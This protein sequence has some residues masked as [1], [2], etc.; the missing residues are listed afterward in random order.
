MEG[1]WIELNCKWKIHDTR[2]FGLT[3]R[4]V[5]VEAVHKPLYIRCI[6]SRSRGQFRFIPKPSYKRTPLFVIIIS[7]VPPPRVTWWK[8][9]LLLDD[10][11]EILPDGSVKNVLH[12]PRI[13]RQHLHTVSRWEFN[14]F[15]RVC[16]QLLPQIRQ[17]NAVIYSWLI[18]LSPRQGWLTRLKSWLFS[19][20]W[21]TD[22]RRSACK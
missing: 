11:F 7:G 18:P 3:D 8:D 6:I 13:N 22:W 16:P 4:S 15:R 21:L 19:D 1:S 12:L 2:C 5:P 20:F 10:T 9:H 14:M 17:M